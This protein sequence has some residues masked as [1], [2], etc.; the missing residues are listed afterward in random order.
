M[1]DVTD[2]FAGREYPDRP[3]PSAAVC[4]VKGDK[5]LVIKRA[6]PPSQELWSLPGGV[7]NLGETIQD[8]AKR[9]VREECGIEVEMGRIFNIENLIVRDE[10]G[11]IHFHYVVS[12]L[13]AHYVSGQPRTSSEALDVKWAT[14]QELVD[15][16]MNPVVRENMLKAFE[17]SALSD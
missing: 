16:D 6:N 14:D 3:F 9:E 2:E 1:N 17:I 4:V 13:V 8:A 7:I 10:T 11:R 15:L 12:Y 5:I